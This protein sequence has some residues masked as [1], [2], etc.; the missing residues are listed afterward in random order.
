MSFYVS[1]QRDG[2]DNCLYL[3]IAVGGKSKA[4]KDILPARY[5]K[6]NGSYLNP[7]D[8]VNIAVD[9]YN[10]W[11]KDYFDERKKLRIVGISNPIYYEFT[12]RGI[13][14]AK[15]WA[16][17]IYADMKKCGSCKRAM[18]SKDPYEHDDLV[19]AVFCSE[20]C[21]AT[22]YREVFGVEP[23]K[24]LSKKQKAGKIK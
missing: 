21:C 12:T 9:I 4:S 23:P 24:V 7:Q 13:A 3:E 11:D 16:D 14:S 20:A 15:A 8:A 18:G 17:K 6:E 10:R 1:R 2:K 22:K 5:D 19:N